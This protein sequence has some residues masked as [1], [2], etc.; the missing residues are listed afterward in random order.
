MNIYVARG[1]VSGGDRLS[2]S[3]VNTKA[4]AEPKKRSSTQ[5]HGSKG[6]NDL[7]S[8]FHLKTP[9]ISVECFYKTTYVASAMTFNL[10]YQLK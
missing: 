6:L 8:R 1:A 9:L 3:H 2:R 4:E 5:P 7:K 10:F